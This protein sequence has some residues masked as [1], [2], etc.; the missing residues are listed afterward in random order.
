MKKAKCEFIRSVLLDGVWIT[1]DT[2]ETPDLDLKYA[3]ELQ[4]KGLVRIKTV[5][6]VPYVLGACCNDHG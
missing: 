3:E 1:P 6:G 5:D 4:G 2:K